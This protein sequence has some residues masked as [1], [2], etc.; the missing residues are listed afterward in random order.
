VHIVLL[1]IFIITS[2]LAS[3]DILYQRLY[4]NIKGKANP[5]YAFFWAIVFLS[6]VWNVGPSWLVLASKDYKVYISLAVVIPVQLIVAMLVRKSYKFPIPGSWYA[7]HSD[8]CTD[9]I[10]SINRKIF[11]CS[12]CACSH[13]IQILSLWSLLITFTFCV[14]YLT[15]VLVSLYIDPLTSI[16][17]LAF[18]KA[19]LICFIIITALIFVVDTFKLE[20]SADCLWRFGS[21]LLSL[22]TIFS[23]LPILIIFLI[24]L[25]GIVFNDAPSQSNSWQPI[26]TL[27]PTGV[28]LIA[29]WFSHGFLFPK[30]RKDPKGSPLKEIVDDVEGKPAKPTNT[31]PSNN[32]VYSQKLETTRLLS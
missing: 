3:S 32:A 23:A 31:E 18:L 9:N 26:L 20:R 6:V 19:M 27:I 28:L 22:L 15:A 11:Q 17:K 7:T 12:R 4:L 2:A 1:N 29:S 25:G 13:V 24:M 16:V 8:R 30:G 10:H 21:S 5:G 14:H